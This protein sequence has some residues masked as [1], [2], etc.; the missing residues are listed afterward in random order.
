MEGGK[1]TFP[2]YGLYPECFHVALLAQEDAS[3]YSHFTGEEAE[4]HLQF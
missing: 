3:Y 1:Y 4:V 2:E